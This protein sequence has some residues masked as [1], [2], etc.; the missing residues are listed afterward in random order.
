MKL[1]QELGM[2][3]ISHQTRRHFLANCAIGLG[4]IW[5]AMAE[6]PAGTQKGRA[7]RVIFLHMAGGPSHLDLF[8]Y[9]PE[10]EKLDGAACPEDL[11]SGRSYPF[12]QGSPRM[13]GPQFPFRKVGQSGQWMS[14]RLPHLGEVVDELCII[15]S[16]WTDQ[17]NHAPAQLLLHTGS[18]LPGSPSL[19]AW[20][21]YGLGRE[22]EN[23]PGFVV[24]TSGGKNPEAGKAAWGSGYLPGIH[25]GVQC[26]SEGDPVL[27]LSNPPGI[28]QATRRLQLEALDELNRESHAR[29][30]DPET[31][32]RIRQYEIAF[33][34]QVHATDAFELTKE[35]EDI[36]RRYG[37]EIGRESFA[38]NCLL[39]RR[40]VERGVRCVQL[41]DW[42]WDSHGTDLRNDL[43]RGFVDKCRQIDRPIAALIT[44]LKQ[45]GLLEETLI[46]WGGEFGRTPMREN[47]GG[48]E[49][50]FVGRDH[51]A[52][53]FSMWLAG[54]GVRRGHSFGTS[55]PFGAT[56]ATDGVSP[57]D[58]HATILSL[59]G[60][61]HEKLT[62]RWMGLEQRLT[63]V[64]RPA[65]VVTGIVDG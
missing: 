46:V 61:D 48:I 40:L 6:G 24:L 34:M 20:L 3:R 30:G 13:L 57:H 36:R 5:R 31:E 1:I 56:V 23:L 32:T 17:A 26:R 10:L 45:R 22:S 51:N 41:F 19:G 60:I 21:T 14:D 11:M 42:G 63:T 59:M 38:N 39:A 25:Q 54:G 27:F 64:T 8:D 9:K 52:A 4:S 35:P 53:A 47:R 44:D 16:M 55:D 29:W 7:K 37:T 18:A 33:R 15:R 28:S 49:M 65:R 12:L 62:H 43:R 58:L 50:P 2:T